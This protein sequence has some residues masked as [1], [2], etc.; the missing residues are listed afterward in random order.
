M[1]ESGWQ[2]ISELQVGEYFTLRPHTYPTE[3]QVWVRG[4][5]NRTTKKYDCYKWDDVCHCRAFDGN[6]EVFTNIIF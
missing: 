1:S 2:T 3:K 4:T 5:Y 6:T